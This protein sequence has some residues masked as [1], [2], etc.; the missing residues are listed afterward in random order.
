LR[1]QPLE[2]GAHVDLLELDALA[3][4]RL[5]E[6]QQRPGDS[7][8]TRRVL[9]DMLEEAVAVA[10]HVF[11]TGLKHFDRRCDSGERC[12]QLVGGVSDELAH[13]LLAAQLFGDVFDQQDCRIVLVRGDA[14]YAERATV[15]QLNGGGGQR[16]RQRD[17]ALGQRAELS[18]T[19]RT[20][21]QDRRSAEDA[22]GAIVRER[23]AAVATDA[24]DRMRK[25]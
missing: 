1:D 9:R 5:G 13:D 16:L 4:L 15:G 17:E 6:H 11:R 23:D 22:Q 18:S 8:Q 24:D 25:T 20:A 3:R 21:D 10:R 12:S 7:R 14:G 2:Q 19:E